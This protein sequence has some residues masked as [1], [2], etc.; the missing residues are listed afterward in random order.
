MGVSE[1]TETQFSDKTLRTETN[2]ERTDEKNVEG[3]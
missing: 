3:K 1:P 2:K